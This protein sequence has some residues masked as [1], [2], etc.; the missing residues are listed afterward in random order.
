MKRHR[1]FRWKN[2]I[3]HLLALLIGLPLLYLLFVV[4]LGLIPV[5]GDRSP[6]AEGIMIGVHTNGAHAGLVLPL[7]NEIMNWNELFPLHHFLSADRKFEAIS[8]GWGDRNF[9][10]NTP[11]WSD[12]KIDDAAY[13]LFWPSPAAMHVELMPEMPLNDPDFVPIKID[14]DQYEKLIMIIRGYLI[15][16]EYMPAPIEGFHYNDRDAFYIADG[17]YHLFFTS[18]EWTARC[19]RR[20]GVRAPIWSP[21]D[22]AVMYHARRYR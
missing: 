14:S 15:R 7:N 16:S 11:E 5:N 20:I 9:Y 22:R 17:Y 4:I 10:L 2:A 1:M 8:I 13:A 3:K 6:P 18:N 21:F 19:L 12:L